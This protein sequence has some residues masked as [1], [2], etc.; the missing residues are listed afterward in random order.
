MTTMMGPMVRTSRTSVVLTTLLLLGVAGCAE[1]GAASAGASPTPTAA[2]PTSPAKASA[3]PTTSAAPDPAPAEKLFPLAVHRRGGFAGVDDRASIAADG[4]VVV[5][6]R[7]RA[8]VRTSLPATTMTQLRR[9]LAAPDLRGTPSDAPAVCNDGYEYEFT[10]PS[11]TLLV[12]D[13]DVP[14][15]ASLDKL[16]AMTAK[17]FNG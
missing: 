15:G 13:C 16:L 10:S 11:A 14:Q 6:R 9:L 8:A 5:T 3:I 17:L 1:N 2:A 7:G 4:S 12:H